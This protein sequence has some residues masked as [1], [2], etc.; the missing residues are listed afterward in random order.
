MKRTN[1][2]QRF[3]KPDFNFQEVYTH[4]QSSSHIRIQSEIITHIRTA[5]SFVFATLQETCQM[6]KRQSNCKIAFNIEKLVLSKSILSTRQCKNWK[7][8]QGSC[9]GYLNGS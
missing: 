5:L 6:Q 2:S 8:Y 9:F 1:L 4:S 7:K 3:D